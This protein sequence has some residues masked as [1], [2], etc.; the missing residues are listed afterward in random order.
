MDP[1]RV[2]HDSK[3]WMGRVLDG[4]GKEGGLLSD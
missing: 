1:T 2:V 4:G 3:T